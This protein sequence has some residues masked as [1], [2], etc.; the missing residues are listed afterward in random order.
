MF[1]HWVRTTNGLQALASNL[2]MT[3][4][5]AQHYGIATHFIDFTTE[6]YVA[7]YF[8]SEGIP[9]QTPRRSGDVRVRYHAS[10]SFHGR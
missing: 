9:K 1:L 3:I 6:P 7:G 10:A 8:A 4:A 2:D 5:V